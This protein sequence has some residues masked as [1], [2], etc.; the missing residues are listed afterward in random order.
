[1]LNLSIYCIPENDK[2]RDDLTKVEHLEDKINTELNVLREKISTM[3]TEL[4]DYRDI[5]TLRK[6]S[7]DKKQ[8]GQTVCNL[9]E[10][11]LI[12][13]ILNLSRLQMHLTHLQ[14]TTF[15]C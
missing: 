12:G 15:E 6:K 10:C 4:V 5:D 2:L 13:N 8:V 14:Q 7:E 1:M 9:V 11:Q 3:E